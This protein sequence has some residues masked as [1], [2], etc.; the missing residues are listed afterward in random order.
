[1]NFTDK[2]FTIW[3]NVVFWVCYLLLSTGYYANQ[4]SFNITLKILI[5]AVLHANLAYLNLLIFVPRFF[6]KR[7]W[8][9]YFIFYI[10]V[11]A[12]TI[13][14]LAFFQAFFVEEVSIGFNHVFTATISSSVVV[15]MIA[16]LKFLQEW[17]KQQ[18]KARLLAF[19]QLQAEHKM[20]RMQVNPHFLFNA[21]NNIY[22]LAYKKSELTPPAIL[23]LSDLM[24]FLL[25]ESDERKIAIQ[26]EIDYIENYIGLM[27]L[28][29]ENVD[30]KIKLNVEGPTNWE[31]EPLLM[32]PFVEN[33]FKH[34]N[35]EDENSLLNI[36]IKTQKGRFEFSIKN[37]F[38]ASD[39]KKDAVGGVGIENVKSRLK[40]YYPDKH[41][42]DV[43]NDGNIYTVTLSIPVL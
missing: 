10:P 21:L 16:M 6:M 39:K 25:Y 34:G 41:L 11:F 20:L 18:E 3:A 27:K 30:A 40:A 37:S 14:A 26:K 32:I 5:T 24:R 9:L 42:L 36:N 2:R 29:Y 12:G 22:Y 28:K 43:K 7:K 35:L 31:I 15:T 13:L 17:Y 19:N 23:K 38:D 1:M 8:L 4:E 33:A